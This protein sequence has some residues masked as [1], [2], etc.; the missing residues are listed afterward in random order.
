MANPANVANL[1]NRNC[2]AFMRRYTTGSVLNAIDTPYIVRPALEAPRD[3]YLSKGLC[4]FTQLHKDC[5][6]PKAPKRRK[7]PESAPTD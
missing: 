4:L 7:P 1:A 5:Y 2:R 3:K 6:Y